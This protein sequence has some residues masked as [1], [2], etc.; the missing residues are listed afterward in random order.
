MAA[1]DMTTLSALQRH[2]TRA[3]RHSTFILS[4]NNKK[5]GNHLPGV[6]VVVA[7][8]TNMGDI[9]LFLVLEFLLFVSVLRN[10]RLLTPTDL[11]LVILVLPYVEEKRHGG[12]LE[13]E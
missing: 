12:D 11:I 6:S 2:M 1:T 13:E 4:G 7:L 8:R 10:V 3:T 5:G 9:S